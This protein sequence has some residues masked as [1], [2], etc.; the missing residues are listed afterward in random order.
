MTT[1]QQSPM[2]ETQDDFPSLLAWLTKNRRDSPVLP[3]AFPGLWHVFRYA[4]V[5]RVLSDTETYSSDMS[6][7]IPTHPDTGWIAKG[8]VVGMDPP[9]HRRL[10]SLVSGAF[11]PRLVADLEPR[12]TELA[13]GLL[14]AVAGRDRFDLV[15]AVTHPLPVFVIAEM[16][17]I[18]LAD[19]PL[20]EKWGLAFISANGGGESALPSEE[21]VL[22]F[23]QTATEMRAYMLEQIALRRAKPGDDLIS[24]LVTARTEDGRLEDDEIVGFVGTLLLAGHITTT[25]VLGSTV[26][27]LDENPGALAEVRRDRSLVPAAVEEAVRLRPAFS[28]LVRMTTRES[29]VGGV[30]IPAGQVLTLWTVAAN[31]D[32]ERF[33]D[34]DGFDLHRDQQ[35][36]HLGFGQGVHFCMGAPLARLEGR[37]V[38]NLLLD[39]FPELSVVGEDDAVAYHHPKNVVGPRRLLVDVTRGA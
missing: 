3:D 39:R 30:T 14:D 25:A 10:R 4:D 16:L 8:N 22:S 9:M 17:G 28:R 29:D 15:E 11:T 2:P 38:L 34:P 26:L 33:D 35:G 21:N 36:R 27:C 32:P 23:V 31:R 7:V 18:P 37:I 13:T 19:R 20:F 24:R 1:D 5:S 6:A 12:I